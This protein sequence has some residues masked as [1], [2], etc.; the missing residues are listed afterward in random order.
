[1]RDNRN[2]KQDG[3][4]EYSK[5][6]LKREIKQRFVTTM[7]AALDKFEKGFG[8]LWGFDQDR[9]LTE[10]ERISKEIWLAIRTEILDKG[11]AQRRSLEEELERYT[12]TWNKYHTEFKIRRR[13]YGQD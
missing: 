12:I 1:M 10:Q 13:D 2:K 9:D 6:R 11:H 7:I 3:Y 4:N 8:Y 5:K